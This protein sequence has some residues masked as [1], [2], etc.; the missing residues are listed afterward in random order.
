MIV[1]CPGCHYQFNVP[2]ARIPPD[3]VVA[4]CRKCG[5]KFRLNPPQS[6][7]AIPPS[8]AAPTNT[9]PWEYRVEVIMEGGI[10]TVLAGS[11]KLSINK[12]NNLLY[13]YGRDGWRMDFMLLEQRRMLLL[14]KREAVI[15]TFSRPARDH[16]AH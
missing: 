4:T 14:W 10:G 8:P 9:G 13:R 12:L 3:G 2:D 1:T 15:I 5:H 6:L 7:P 11:S 16:G